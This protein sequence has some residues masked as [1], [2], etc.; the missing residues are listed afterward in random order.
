M[1]LSAIVIGG[2]FSGLSTAI[3]LADQGY[4]V[5]LLEKNDVITSSYGINIKLNEND[6]SF[7][8]PFYTINDV[9]QCIDELNT[10]KHVTGK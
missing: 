4:S 6:K 7:E 3:T 10:E 9:Y 5:K 1:S 8:L 2:G